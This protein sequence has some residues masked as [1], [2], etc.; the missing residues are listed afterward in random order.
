MNKTILNQY[1]LKE[2]RR[3]Y[4][5]RYASMTDLIRRNPERAIAILKNVTMLHSN[6]EVICK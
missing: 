3:Y 4:K 5:E 6:K 1:F 2:L